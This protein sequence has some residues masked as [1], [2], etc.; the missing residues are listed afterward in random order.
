MLALMLFGA[1]LA[2]LSTQRAARP[3][4]V[5]NVT[6]SA[7]VGLYR[8]LPLAPVLH[9]GELVL[10]RPAPADARLYAERGYLPAGVPLL[11]RI[12]ATTGQTVCEQNGRVSI[13]GRYLASALP[14]DVRGRPLAAW[15]GCRRLR[16]DE[17]FVLM[18]DVP[19][20]LDGRYFGPTATMSLIGCA[21]PL[22]TWSIR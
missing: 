15:S 2:C 1:A 17:I 16:A 22:W 3:T 4:L 8:V 12:A 20:S 21:Q 18:A 13:D 10:V 14:V 5:W 9:V 11:K 19:T 7:P 6:G